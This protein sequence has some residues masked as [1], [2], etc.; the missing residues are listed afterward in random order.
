VIVPE[1]EPPDG[2][3][4]IEAGT[5]AD[6]RTDN[7]DLTATVIDLAIRGYVKIIETVNKRVLRKDTKIYSLRLQNADFSKLN[8]FEK[9]LLNG[10]FSQPE[11]GQEISLTELKYKLSSTA[12]DLQKKVKDS[13]I[14]RGYI[15]KNALSVSLHFVGRLALA[16]VISIILAVIFHGAAVTLGIA[17]GTALAVVFMILMP[18]RTAQGV[19]AKESILGLKMYLEVAEAERIKK[20]QSPGAPYAAR[21]DAPKKTVELFEKLLPYAMVLGVEQQWAKQ[22]ADIY[23]TPPD[24]YHGNWTTFNAVYLAASLNSGVQSSI[25]SAFSSPSS[26][27]SSGFGGGGSGGGGGGGGG[28]GW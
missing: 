25:N 21:S 6:F 19:A 18:A 20:L 12:S 24:W 27:S 3:R 11:K 8:E 16:Y 9:I 5:V 23:R 17:L 13:L 4:P 26:S 22:F 10:I 14:A 1:Y 7:R 15:H 28:G 2:L